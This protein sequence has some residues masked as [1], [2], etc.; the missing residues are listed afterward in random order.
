MNKIYKK[1]YPREIEYEDSKLFEKTMHLSWVEPNMIIPGDTSLDALDN[2]L[3]DI[4]EEFKKLNKATSPYIKLKCVKKIFEYIS[5]I[6]KFNDGGE[7]GNREVGAED[8]TPYLNYVLIRACPVRIFSDIKFIK[9]FLKNEGKFEYDFLNVEMMC[10][11]ILDSTYKNFHISE[12][13]FI[14]KCNEAIINNKNNDDKRFNE[15]IGRFEIT[16]I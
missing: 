2:I 11:T 10:R 14:K 7:G 3:P 15:I 13:E 4:L 5:I 16:N 9:Y 1:I 12:S 6:V 8:I